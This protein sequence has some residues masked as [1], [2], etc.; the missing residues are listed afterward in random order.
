MRITGEMLIGAAGVL[1]RE[2]EVRAVDAATGEPLEPTFG[3]AN[4]NRLFMASA[5]SIYAL[6]VNTRGA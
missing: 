2:G 6:Y 3:G 4:R 1:G 5:R